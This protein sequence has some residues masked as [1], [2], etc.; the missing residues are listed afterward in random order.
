MSNNFEL[1]DY[2]KCFATN[3]TWPN[4]GDKLTAAFPLLIV[5]IIAFGL[6]IVLIATILKYFQELTEKIRINIL[7]MNLC[8]SHC[9]YLS[10]TFLV[11]TPAAFSSVPIY[12]SNNLM[13]SL[14]AISSIGFYAIVFFEFS[15][16]IDRFIVFYSEK[17]LSRNAYFGFILILWFLSISAVCLQV[18]HGCPKRYNQWTLSYSFECNFGCIGNIFGFLPISILLNLGTYLTYAVF[19]LYALVFLKI[20]HLKSLHQTKFKAQKKELLVLMQFFAIFLCTWLSTTSMF[21]FPTWFGRSM[22]TNICPMILIALNALLNAAL[23]ITF[24]VTIR[25]KVIQFLHFKN[26]YKPKTIAV[27]PHTLSA[28]QSFTSRNNNPNYI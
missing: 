20:V 22:F 26:I 12:Y 9:L 3:K 17:K 18:W 24:N 5:T 4:L 1:S 11:Q 6:N 2:Q 13:I 27:S 23:L 15:V 8:F 28:H 14:T 10:G 7:L 25:T 16:A 19:G 21:V